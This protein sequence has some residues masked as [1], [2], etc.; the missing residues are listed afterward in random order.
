MQFINEIFFSHTRRPATIQN[1]LRQ[2]LNMRPNLSYEKCANRKA[3]TTQWQHRHRIQVRPWW[4]SGL[5]H[6]VVVYLGTKS[7]D[8]GSMYF[9]NDGIHLHVNTM[10]EPRKIPRTGVSFTYVALCCN[11]IVRSP[12]LKMEMV[13]S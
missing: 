4:S 11:L 7:E 3:L 10:S 1:K 12:D 6:P 5:R 2:F 8:R 9:R 13:A